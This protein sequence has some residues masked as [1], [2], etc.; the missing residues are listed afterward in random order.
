M[1][2]PVV[3]LGIVVGSYVASF[4]T[5]GPSTDWMVMKH[6]AGGTTTLDLQFPDLIKVN[7]DGAFSRINER[8]LTRCMFSFFSALVFIFPPPL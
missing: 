4:T 3:R 1:A 2:K 8:M 7:M 5:V 6:K